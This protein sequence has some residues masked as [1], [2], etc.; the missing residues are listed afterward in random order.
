MDPDETTTIL[1]K[2]NKLFDFVADERE[3][4]EKSFKKDNDDFTQGYWNAMNAIMKWIEKQK[5]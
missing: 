3:K 4:A 5:K 1:R 2:Y